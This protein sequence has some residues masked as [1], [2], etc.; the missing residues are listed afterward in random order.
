MA[1]L[2]DEFFKDCRFL[3][4]ADRT[5]SSDLI[6]YTNGIV[7]TSEE[8]L[9]DIDPLLEKYKYREA[10]GTMT[11]IGTLKEFI[12]LSAVNISCG[13]YCAHTHNEYGNIKELE[14]CL[15]FIIDIIK[16]N[17]KV[18]PHKADLTYSYTHYLGGGYGSVGRHYGYDSYVRSYYDDYDD[19]DDYYDRRGTERVVAEYY[20]PSANDK[21]DEDFYNNL[22]DK[23][24]KCKDR[25]RCDECP[26]L[27]PQ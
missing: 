5:G 23:C 21:A 14:N 3:L 2:N 26:H 22:A 15:N 6:T 24:E 8:F 9:K 4:E 17:D 7:V 12:D 1:A 13:Y 11:D 20:Q 10:R 27:I 18:Y 19:W 16:L 25:T